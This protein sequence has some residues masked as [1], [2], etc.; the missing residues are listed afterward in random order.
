[1]DVWGRPA[2]MSGGEEGRCQRAVMA[3]PAGNGR[4]F[5]DAPLAAAAGLEWGRRGSGRSIAFHCTPVEKAAPAGRRWAPRARFAGARRRLTVAWMQHVGE[6]GV[7]VGPGA[8]AVSCAGLGFGQSQ[9]RVYP[10]VTSAART[11]CRIRLAPLHVFHMRAFGA[12]QPVRHRESGS[13]LIVVFP[14]RASS[15]EERRARADGQVA[16]QRAGARPPRLRHDRLAGG[17]AFPVT[18][19]AAAFPG[20]RL[21]LPSPVTCRPVVRLLRRAAVDGRCGRAF[22]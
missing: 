22:T 15:A 19:P 16:G 6:I 3:P 9:R 21:H 11:Q 10:D 7:G 4:A 13:R 18:L 20:P 5:V 2:S 8:C 14:A 17:P 12:G 1:M